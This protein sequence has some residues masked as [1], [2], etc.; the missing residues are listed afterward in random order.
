VGED[1][2]GAMIAQLHSLAPVLPVQRIHVIIAAADK[3]YSIRHCRRGNN[4]SSCGI[5][6]HLGTGAGVQRIHVTVVGAEINHPVHDRRRGIREGIESA[7]GVAP[8]QLQT[9]NVADAKHRLI[10]VPALHVVPMELCPV[11]G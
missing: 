3:Y 9:A 5:A 7:I 2:P 1:G 10:W 8:L 11:P 4:T 6:P